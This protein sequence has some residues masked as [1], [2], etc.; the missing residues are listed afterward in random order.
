MTAQEFRTALVKAISATI[1]ATWE[2][3]LKLSYENPHQ[4]AELQRALLLMSVETVRRAGR[5]RFPFSEHQVGY[6]PWSLEHVHAQH[7]KSI[8]KKH[9]EQWLQ[10][11]QRALK[12][13]LDQPGESA[14]A[15][16]ELLERVTAALEAPS[17]P[18]AFDALKDDVLVALTPAD[19]DVDQMHSVSNLALL[20]REHNSAL[21]NSAF[22]AKRT[23]IIDMDR[24]GEYVPVATRNLFL[25]YYTESDLPQLYQWSDED[26]KG[27]LA[28]MAKLLYPKVA[29]S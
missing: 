23:R 22:T 8:E 25:K 26:Q 14:G 27:Y 29:V 4:K 28:N 9:Q 15:L 17:Q 3:L 19:F 10:D 12:I 11:H 1:P 18:E 24:A 5:E 6:K 13:A 16:S 21:N 7:S 20:S 2:K